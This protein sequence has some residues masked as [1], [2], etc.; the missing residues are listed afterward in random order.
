MHQTKWLEM[1]VVVVPWMGRVGDANISNG[2]HIVSNHILVYGK[3]M[4]TYGVCV[5]WKKT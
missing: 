1:N 5:E 3:A 4:K 2:F